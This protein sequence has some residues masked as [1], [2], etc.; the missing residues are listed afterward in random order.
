[1][2]LPFS[3]PAILVLRPSTTAFAPSFTPVAMR[4]SMRCLLSLEITGP[5]CTPLSSPKPTWME[6][7]ASAMASRKVLCASPI[8]KATLPG[9]AERGITDDLARE[10]HVGVRQ[11]DDVVLGTA[12]ALHALSG[13]GGALVNMFGNGR[14][15]NEADGT[16]GR[17]ITECVDDFL[18]AVNDVD[19]SFREARLFEE[20][21]DTTHAQWH[22]LA[23]LEHEGVAA[24]NR[25]GEKPERNHCGKVEGSNGSDDAKR[26]A[27]KH[28]VDA[29]GDVFKVVA[30]HHRGNAA[31]D[32]DIFDASA[33]LGLGLG[34]GLPVL[35]SDDAG[36]FVDAVFEKGLELEEI[37]NALAGGSS[38]PGGER[39][40]G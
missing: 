34:E 18:A 15:A 36:K 11:Y 23:G 1:M 17:V 3:R 28:F 13:G 24:G 14:G 7:A 37:L 38:A 2:K 26:L 20:F 19:H 33:Q 10:V 12:L 29:G 8:V 35:E 16:D 39:F 6:E 32:F 22:A 31:S 25:V 9:A 30:L 40:G 21:V 4:D 5:I 27:D